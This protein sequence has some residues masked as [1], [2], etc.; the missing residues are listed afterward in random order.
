[1]LIVTAVL[2]VLGTLLFAA[3]EWNNPKTIGNMSF[4]NKLLN[5]FFQSVTTRTAGFAS[6]S[7]GEMTPASKLVCMLLMIIGASP[8]GTGGGFK[9]TTLAVMFCL[10]K[11]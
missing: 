11:A 4:G 3:F 2:L 8:A 1:M 7:Q 6:F 9:T 5:A 10:L